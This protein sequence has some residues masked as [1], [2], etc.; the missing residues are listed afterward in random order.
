MAKLYRDY[1]SI[2]V[3]LFGN[4]ISAEFAKPKKDKTPSQ[5]QSSKSKFDYVERKYLSAVSISPY[6]LHKFKVPE[7]GYNYTS[8][9]RDNQ[10]N[11]LDNNHQGKISDKARKNIEKCLN[12]LLYEAK[13][14]RVVDE[15]SGSKFF[16]KIN[17]ITLTLPA[18]Q[19]HSDVVI[20]DKCLAK[21]IDILI[22]VKG[23]NKYLWRAEAQINGNIHFHLIT[24]TYIH[25]SYIREQWNKCLEVLGYVTAFEL[26][27]GHKNPNSTDVHSIKH[28]NRLVSYVSKYI[29]KNR[30]FAKIGEIRQIGTE[31][32][33]VLYGS[34]KYRSEAANKKEGK[35]IGSV[36]AG[37]VR[38]IDGKLW[39][40]S[41]SLSAKKSIFVT[42]ADFDLS[43][44][45]S[46]VCHDSVRCYTGQH[47]WSYYGEI[48]ALCKDSGISLDSV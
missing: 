22:K 40:A 19:V 14:K 29:A 47:V 39:G 6:S 20:K 35:V 15:A 27:H 16:F 24:D 23:L 7:L 11:L 46:V 18:H 31:V 4:V 41:R 30:P 36:I 37:L 44:L 38:P 10:V 28:V 34:D 9:H 5:A 17:M 8:L 45:D 33:E 25:H 26:K 21:F 3:D 13:Y 43:V 48:M 32:V 12:W 1:R 42:E 2:G